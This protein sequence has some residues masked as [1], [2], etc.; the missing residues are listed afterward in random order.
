MSENLLGRETSPYL[1]Q[2]KDN[3]VHWRPW[4]PEAL[5]EAAETKRPILLSVGYAACHWCHVMA[6]ECF[7]NPAIAARMNELFVSVKVDREE[8]PDVDAIYQTALALLGQQGGWPLTMFLTPRAEPFWGGT[9]FPPDSRHGR[10]GFADVLARMHQAY[11]NEPEAVA[12]NSAGLTSALAQISALG[13]PDGGDG[14]TDD[15]LEAAC[16]RSLAEMD[17]VHGGTLGAP[18][19][20]RPFSLELLWR[21]WRRTGEA[22][23]A[24]AVTV[25]LDNICQGGIYDHLG[26]GFSRYSVDDIWLAPHFEKMLYDNALMIDALTMVWQDTGN[27][28]YQARVRETVA[29]VLREMVAEGGAFAAA[30]DADSEGQ[31]GRFYVW[32]QTEIED[33]LGDGAGAFMAAYDVRPSGNWE[34]TT[35]LNRLR[36]MAPG[37]DAEEGALA[38][39][40]ARLLGHREGRVRPGWDDKVLADW[41]GLMI[42]ALARAGAAFGEPA[43][44]AVA[45]RAFDF[46]AASMALEGAPDR[47]HHAHRAGL[48]R[49]PAVLDD[50]ANMINAALALGEA[51]GGAGYLARAEAWAATV[52]AHYRDPGNGGYY[53]TADDAE[54]L[55][56]RTRNATDNATP[57]GN[58]ALA[59]AFARLYHLTGKPGHR[60]AADGILAAFCGNLDDHYHAL[61]VCLMGFEDLTSATQIVIAGAR[62]EAAT[63]A[64]LE[65]AFGACH[66]GRVIAVVGAGAGES[67]PA[68]HPAHG[69]GQVG[70]EAGGEATAYVCS[71]ATCS[72]PVTEPGA[73]T[74]ALKRPPGQGA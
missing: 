67:L 38:E 74:A 21:A 18:K 11:T 57:S 42:A 64:L 53:F 44:L 62:G 24:K 14:I 10:P 16:R 32:S 7:E 13:A 40:R 46:V 28:L 70:G 66:A 65:A 59:V 61:P 34:G 9:Y 58:G 3:P 48:S 20:P 17:M 43:W 26:G 37:T 51:V 50:Y 29:W 8:R 56:A 23:Y 19:F 31:E 33:L 27:P 15:A 68:S 39:Q 63:D 52:E 12:S 30:L 60:D 2:H 71:G 4:G 5:A 6:H 73:L 49:H 55:I 45:A 69:K 54:S 25:S 35:I 72:L 41:N 1:L 47:L 22:D 36:A